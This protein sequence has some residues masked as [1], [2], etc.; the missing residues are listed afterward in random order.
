VKIWLDD[1][2]A[3]QHPGWTWV[4]TPTEAIQALQGGRATHLSLDH[5]LGLLSGNREETG[6]DVLLWLE[7]QVAHGRWPHALPDMFP[8][9][10]NSSARKRMEQAIAAILRIH[11]SAG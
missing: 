2:R 3:P 5:D 9:T 6:M 8:H 1:E 10:A 11:N 4:K 7:G